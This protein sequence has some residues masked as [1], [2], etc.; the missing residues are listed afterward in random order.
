MIS[1]RVL[2]AAVLTIISQSV[3]ASQPKKA[4]ENV[5]APVAQTLSAIIQTAAQAGFITDKGDVYS[6]DRKWLVQSALN[7]ESLGNSDLEPQERAYAIAYTSNYY[8]RYFIN[9]YLVQ[10]GSQKLIH[11][12]KAYDSKGVRFNSEEP[13]VT[14]QYV[15][16]DLNEQTSTIS[17]KS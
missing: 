16:V 6:P 14:I 8:S 5:T 4:L 1:N 17:L 13:S 15:D 3:C 9:I 10:K 7:G 2:L 11:T 12:I